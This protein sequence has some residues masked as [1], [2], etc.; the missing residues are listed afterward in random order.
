MEADLIPV[1]KGREPT[2]WELKGW[3]LSLTGLSLHTKILIK[4]FFSIKPR[5]LNV[6]EQT[7]LLLH[8][9]GPQLQGQVVLHVLSHLCGMF[10]EVEVL[11]KES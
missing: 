3:L 2:V 7:Y 10:A 9:Q 4:G 5:S 1:L 6:T 11:S 8:C